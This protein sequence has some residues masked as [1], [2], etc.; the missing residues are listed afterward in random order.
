[1]VFC[2]PGSHHLNSTWMLSAGPRRLPACSPLSR[3]GC[4]LQAAVR[5][6][7]CPAPWSQCR[8]PTAA[9]VYFG[10]PALDRAT[11]VKAEG[12]VAAPGASAAGPG[13]RSDLEQRL[14]VRRVPD[15]WDL[16]A[17]PADWIVSKAAA[18]PSP[19]R[20]AAL[21]TV[22][23]FH[24]DE[25]AS[26]AKKPTEKPPAGQAPLPPL[27]SCSGLRAGRTCLTR[28]HFQPLILS[29]GSKVAG[30]ARSPPFQALLEGGFPGGFDESRNDG[31]G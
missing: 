23:G 12:G 8:I 19:P 6:E 17:S 13:R 31:G 15:S 22:A 9:A 30:S 29:A 14:P 4:W 27:R 5:W 26:A 11:G 16:R 2:P 28:A 25:R 10:T 24:G 18:K 7:L 3:L 21:R 20:H 1:M